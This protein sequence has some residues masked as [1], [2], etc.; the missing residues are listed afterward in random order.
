MSFDYAGG[1][2]GYATAELAARSI[3]KNCQ[4]VETTSRSDHEST[5]VVET[6]DGEVLANLTVLELDDRWRVDHLTTCDPSDLSL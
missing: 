4:V 1:P 6:S 2:G 5:F 3:A